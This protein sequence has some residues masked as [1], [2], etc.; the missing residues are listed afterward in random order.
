MKVKK[1]EK[2]RVHAFPLP[3]Q[4]SDKDF[5]KGMFIGRLALPARR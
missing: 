2:G 5:E 3:L 1:R 4:F